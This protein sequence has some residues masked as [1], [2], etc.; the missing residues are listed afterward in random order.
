MNLIYDYE[1]LS[2]I[3]ET[4]PIVC[5]S[6]LLFDESRFIKDPYTFEEL[7]NSCKLFKYSIE[8]QVRDYG[9]VIE[10]DCLDWWKKNVDIETRKVLLTPSKDDRPF[11]GLIDDLRSVVGDVGLNFVYTRGNTFDPII[12]EIIA[13]ETGKSMPYPWWLIRDTRSFLSGLLYGTYIKQDFIPKGCE[14]FKKHDPNQDIALDVMRI[15][16]AV[17]CVI[18]DTDHG[19]VDVSA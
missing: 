2:Q 19:V 17:Q 9:K 18:V 14:G 10:L 8:E 4:A 1:T 5:F 3:K 12:T 16:T 6:G 13:A 11:G 15:Q 7:T